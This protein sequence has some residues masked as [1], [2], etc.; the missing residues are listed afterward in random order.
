MPAEPAQHGGIEVRDG[1]G[2]TDVRFW[3]EVDV[4]VRVGGTAPLAGL[5][6]GTGLLTVDCRD[7]DFMDSTGMS[8]LVRIVR[9]ATDDGRPVRF[10]GASEPVRHLL[11]VTGFD[12]WM[13]RLG[14]RPGA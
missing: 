10:L 14:V 9:D 7:V 5:R 3:G 8:I 12:D 4:A 2:V 13:T 6:D 1:D 11:E